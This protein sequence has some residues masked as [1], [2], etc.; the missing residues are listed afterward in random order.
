[1]AQDKAAILRGADEVAG[2]AVHSQNRT[3]SLC[4]RLVQEETPGARIARAPGLLSLAPHLPTPCNFG[5]IGR[6]GR[7]GHKAA[8]ADFQG[9]GIRPVVTINAM[10][11]VSHE[12]SFERGIEI[13]VL[14]D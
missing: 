11:L 1:M 4:P 6:A 12:D 5:S 13:V 14:Q 10:K 3:G 2:V 8:P 7:G 9:P